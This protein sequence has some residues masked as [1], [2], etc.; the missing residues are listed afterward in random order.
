[1]QKWFLG[2]QVPLILSQGWFCPRH[3][4]ST[5]QAHP[6][7]WL[8]ARVLRKVVAARKVVHQVWDVVSLERPLQVGG[9]VF[10]SANL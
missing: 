4:C 7:W 5:L 1:M 3:T 6:H 2:P 8:N 9:V 10:R